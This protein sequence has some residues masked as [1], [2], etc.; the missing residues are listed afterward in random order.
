M[1]QY[2]SKTVY[3]LRAFKLYICECT[4]RA[5]FLTSELRALENFSLPIPSK[6][7]PERWLRSDTP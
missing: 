1:L 5:K 3:S 4:V 7:T 2:G 6:N